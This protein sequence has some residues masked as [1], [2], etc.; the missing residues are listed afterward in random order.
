M[1]EN[2]VPFP[3]MASNLPDQLQLLLIADHALFRG[4]DPVE[5]CRSAVQG[6]V[7]AVQLRWKGGAP[8]DQVALARRLREA[9]PVPVFVNDRPDIA[10]A[11]GCA[12][13]HLG[14]DDLAIR[15]A[16]RVVPPGFLLGASVGSEPES[17]GIAG[18]DYVGVGPWRETTTKADAGA[19]PGVAGIGELIR[20]VAPVP[21]VVIGG[22]RPDDVGPA[23]HIGA[24][25][26]AVGAGIL[27][28]DDVARAAA[29]YREARAARGRVR[30]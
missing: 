7:T 11:A 15:L 6:G 20:M 9:L 18:C 22:I 21:V 4:R 23:L 24:T 16:R 25:G 14:A 30:S 10:L 2:G 13:A 29:S 26:V 12:G 1:N 28:A 8:R 5:L 3:D 27:R 19:S 17:R